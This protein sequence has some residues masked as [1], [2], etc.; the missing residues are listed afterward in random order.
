MR[1]G[2]R[3][4]SLR[5]DGGRALGGPVGWL[6]RWDAACL[7]LVRASESHPAPARAHPPLSHALADLL[8]SSLSLPLWPA[9]QQSAASR[10]RSRSRVSRRPRRSSARSRRCCEQE[11]EGTGWDRAVLVLDPGTRRDET[12]RAAWCMQWQAVLSDRFVP[13]GGEWARARRFSTAQPNDAYPVRSGLSGVALPPPLPPPPPAPAPAA[14]PSPAQDGVLTRTGLL[15]TPAPDAAGPAG[16]STDAVKRLRGTRNRPDEPPWVTQ[17]RGRAR[18][19]GGTR[20]ACQSERS[21]LTGETRG[22]GEAHLQP[23]PL[24]QA[25]ADENHRWRQ[26]RCPTWQHVVQLCIRPAGRG[27]GGLSGWA[28]GRGGPETQRNATHQRRA[29]GTGRRASRAGACGTCR[30]TPRH[31]G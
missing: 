22:R 6:R 30:T 26:S 5:S 3:G 1:E 12:R 15:S 28:G 7:D 31:A 11:R 29:G 20:R 8:L 24:G 18:V 16:G 4:L 27:G 17:L 13:S 23:Q 19:R 25:S 14:P 21:K 2:R 10:S 9:T